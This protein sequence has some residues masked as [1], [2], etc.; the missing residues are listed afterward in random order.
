MKGL[1]AISSHQEL[2]HSK[3]INKQT[4]KNAFLSRVLTSF[5]IVNRQKAQTVHHAAKHTKLFV[6]LELLYQKVLR[7]SSFCRLFYLYEL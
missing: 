5:D 1:K 4:V 6:S 7:S 2:L 3:C